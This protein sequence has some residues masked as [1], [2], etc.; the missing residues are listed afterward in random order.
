LFT[1]KLSPF[2]GYQF[3]FKRKPTQFKF[4]QGIIKFKQEVFI[5]NFF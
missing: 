2:N 1:N 4:K 3:L 5:Y